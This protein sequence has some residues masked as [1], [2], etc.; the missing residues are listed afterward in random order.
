M[1]GWRVLASWVQVRGF[2]VQRHPPALRVVSDGCEQNPG[3]ILGKHVPQSASVV[4]HGDQAN[5]GQCD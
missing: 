1:A 5:T 3:A 2:D 4:V